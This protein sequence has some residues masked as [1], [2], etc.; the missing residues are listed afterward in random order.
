MSVRAKDERNKP[1]RD[2]DDSIGRDEDSLVV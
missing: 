1:L 2:V